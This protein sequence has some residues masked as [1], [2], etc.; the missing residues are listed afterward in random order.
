MSILALIALVFV[1]SASAHPAEEQG[2]TCSISDAPIFEILYLLL[3]I[4]ITAADK[5][6]GQPEVAVNVEKRAEERDGWLLQ[7]KEKFDQIPEHVKAELEKEVRIY[8]MKKEEERAQ[9]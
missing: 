5:T 7:L 1:F 2:M 4:C 6:T 9:Q 3:V 8:K